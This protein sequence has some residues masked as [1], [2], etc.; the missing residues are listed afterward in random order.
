MA[1][2]DDIIKE[3]GDRSWMRHAACRGVD[4]K[5][6]FPEERSSD[7]VSTIRN[8]KKVCESCVV[9]VPCLDYG[10]YEQHGIWGGTSRNERRKITKE[11][12]Q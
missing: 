12:V 5:L 6:F 4:P 8:A 10:K 9:R 1:T 3:L 11:E 2:I 7:T